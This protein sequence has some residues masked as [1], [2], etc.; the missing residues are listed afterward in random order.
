MR[1]I[2]ESS[3]EEVT[4]NWNLK[5]EQQL[6]RLKGQDSVKEVEGKLF[7]QVPMKHLMKK[8]KLKTFLCNCNGGCFSFE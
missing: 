3:P 1:G 7:Q 2:L 5:G 4:L 6:T 8:Q